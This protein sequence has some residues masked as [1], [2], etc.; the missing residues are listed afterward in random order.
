[1]TT[2]LPNLFVAV[3]LEFNQPS[4]A[5]IQV[6]AVIGD[7]RTG[8]EVARFCSLVNPN[9]DLNPRIEELCRISPVELSAAS[10]LS[11]VFERFQAWLT[12][13]DAER[14]LNPLTWGGADGHTFCE[15]AG[16]PA[17][18]FGRRWIDVKT[19]FTGYSLANGRPGHGGLASSM[20]A[21]GLRFQ[22][23]KHNA[24]DDA[25]N[26]FLMFHRL[27]QLLKRAEG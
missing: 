23:Q 11:E 16:Q 10:S 26:T 19:L 8:T 13:F 14:H 7:V 27:L 6:G 9:E 15:K 12:P 25:A 18:V 4:G 17:V 3:D 1:M 20:R 24:A 21:V 22:G 5:L 2:S